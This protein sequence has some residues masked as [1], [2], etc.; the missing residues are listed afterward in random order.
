MK[1]SRPKQK[2]QRKEKMS[3][4]PDI[5][6]KVVGIGG[7][8]GNAVSRMSRDFMK[9]V[10]FIAINTDHQDLD[11]CSVRRKIYIGKS[12]TRGFGTGMN[13]EIGR[14]AAEENRSEIAEALSGTD[15]I[16][17]AAGLGG[18]TGT[19]AAPVVAEIA[20]QSGAL[21]VAFV[22]K[23]FSFEGSQRD[24]IAQEGMIKLREK[25]DALMIVPNDRIFSIISK[26]TP[27]LKAFAAID[28]I[29]KNA[30]GGI[31]EVIVS[32]GIINLDFADVRSIMDGA[33]TAVIGLGI[34]SGQ[35]R[36]A[37]AVRQAINSPLLE[38]SAEGAKGVLLGISG[39]SDMKMN[40]I[41]E[42][43]KM[44]AQAVDPGAKIIFGA[45]RDRKLR[46]NQ[47]KITL[48]ATGINGVQPAN[49]L[50]GSYVKR[51]L[52]EEDLPRF[53][54]A[55]RKF[56]DE[57]TGEHSTPS[58]GAAKEKNV[59]STE[60]KQENQEPKKKSIKPDKDSDIWE[61]PTFL[62]RKKK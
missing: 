31:V 5:S 37:E 44:V 6:I 45:Y 18:G 29:L 53:G 41:N 20:K 25:V 42:A 62:R 57:K 24:R 1:K 21:T 47:L 33:G 15:L 36:A 26:D 16:F 34:A 8:G 28:D 10:E 59:S 9:G 50:F 60:T 38:I 51:N 7:G 32:P 46:P 35:D 40:E 19:G 23:P 56:R 61:I 14:Q 17:I 49:S 22:T 30:L 12:L 2:K 58:F 52:A 54:E 48:I 55:G 4:N 27:L 43:A 39:G 13:P 3:G 11:H